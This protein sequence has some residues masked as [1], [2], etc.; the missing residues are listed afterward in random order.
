M[1]PDPS[2]K[3]GELLGLEADSDGYA[4]PGRSWA[5]TFL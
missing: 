1:L 5:T 4:L 3:R 2:V